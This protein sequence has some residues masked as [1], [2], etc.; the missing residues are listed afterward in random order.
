MRGNARCRPPRG[1]AAGPP[2][3][4]GR[5]CAVTQLRWMYAYAM[6]TCAQLHRAQA[7]ARP[8]QPCDSL[9]P[10]RKKQGESRRDAGK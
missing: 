8:L 1:S 3:H 5:W 2:L 4:D 10:G 6:A 7:M 9:T